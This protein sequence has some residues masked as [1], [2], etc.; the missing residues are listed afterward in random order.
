[1]A[2]KKY[3]TVGSDYPEPFTP[4]QDW[5]TATLLNCCI[6]CGALASAPRSITVIHEDDP[7][8]VNFCGFG[9]NTSTVLRDDLVAALFPKGILEEHCTASAVESERGAIPFT[10]FFPN[11]SCP[12]VV[13]GGERSWFWKCSLCGSLSY[14]P[15]GP[16]YLLTEPTLP[17]HPFFD[18]CGVLIIPEANRCLL[19]PPTR[20]QF[21]IQKLR[22]SA[23]PQDGLPP[24]LRKASDVYEFPGPSR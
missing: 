19:G 12:W 16:R 22:L 10:A 11:R 15:I 14:T 6:R 8:P 3:V 18:V 21:T 23:T 1:M 7:C 5:T 17:D 2:T 9:R 24:D 20:G 4:T 13:R